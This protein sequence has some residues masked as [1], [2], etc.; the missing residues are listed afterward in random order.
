MLKRSYMLLIVIM[1][2]TSILLVSSPALASSLKGE[3]GPGGNNPESSPTVSIENSYIKA[4]SSNGGRFVN[5]TTGGD[6]NTP[7]DDNKRLLYGYSTDVGSS[8]STLR[9]DNG[10]NISDYR[11]GSVNW[12]SSGIAPVAPPTSDGITITTIWEKDGV[13]VEERIY[14]VQNSATGRTDTTAIEYTLRNNNSS[15]RSVGLRIMLDVMIGNNDGAPYFILGTGQVTQQAEWNGGNVPDYWTAYESPSF[16]PSSLKGRGQLVGDNTIRPDRFII[17]DWPQADETVWNYTI[18]PSDPV[19]NDSAVILYYNPVTLG[20]NQMRTIRTNYGIAPSG[21]TAQLELTGLE[22]TQAIQNW[23]NEVVLIQDR[24][25]YVR[26]HVQSTSG[27]VDDV[28]AELIGK[29]NGNSLPGS[30]LQPANIGG[31]IDI[32]ENPNRL[33]LN[34]SFFFELPASWRNGTIELELRGVNKTINC[35]DHTGT[36]ND[37]KAQVTFTASPAADVRF[38]GIVWKEGDIRHEPTW[39]DIH[40]VVKEIESTYPIPNLTWDRPYD[41]EPVFFVGQ[42][43]EPW[44]FNRMNIMLKINRTLDGCISGWPVYCNRYYLG[45]LVDPP[46]SGIVG[47]ADNIPANVATAYDTGSFTP[48]HELGHAAG[49]YHTTCLGEEGGPDPNYPYPGGRIS[50]DTS[51]DDAFFGFDI[52]RKLIYSPQTGDLMSYCKPR[53]TS[54]WTY[55]HIRDHFVTRYGSTANSLYLLAG[56]PAVVVSGIVTPNQESGNLSSL[57][58]VDS[59]ISVGLPDPGSYT[60]R[61]EN[62][63][64]QEIASYSFEPDYGVDLHLE[65]NNSENPIGTFALLLPRNLNATRVFLLHGDQI[66]DMQVKSSNSPNV[67][68]TYPNGGEILSDSSTQIGWIASDVDGDAL[69]YV[70]QYSNDGGDNWETL[71]SEWTTTS[72][73]LNLDVTPGTNQGLIRVLASDGFLTSQDQSDGI[74][75]IAKHAPQ[76]T[77]QIPE[78]NALFVGSQYIILEGNAYDAE[79]GLLEDS[80]LNWNSNINGNLG[81][82]HSLAVNASSLAEGTHIITLSAIDSDGQTSTTNITIQ[83]YR[84]RPVLP[85]L[86]SVSPTGLSFIA[87][88]DGGQTDWQTLSIRNVGDGSMSWSV[89]TDQEWIRVSSL[90]GYAPTDILIAVDPTGLPIGQYTGNLTIEASGATNSPQTL[91]VI[92][93]VR[94]IQKV[95]LPIIMK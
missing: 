55:T 51:G 32:L 39:G 70:V 61:F 26:A 67:A 42:P 50:Q 4:L 91:P 8:F 29:R 87:I 38:V 36:Y 18:N 76:P 12:G 74:F 73:E 14:F 15:N 9:I 1:G 37:C 68:V 75:T 27:T 54:D 69:T 45:I 43:S 62:S 20:A 5:G 40:S 31:N 71:V 23:K 94:Q 60:I 17:A 7:N 84:F 3:K 6:P 65:L 28:T 22:V 33:Q 81:T 59:P 21:E 64:G 86:L 2:L 78:T 83:I 49:R 77:I 80:A 90:N 95:Y 47:M 16:D 93:Y 13:R 63:I 89:N 30:P 92:L 56:E 19:T 24:P 46:T 58:S 10:G 41:I 25:T 79:D 88:E 72:Y 11:L 44:Q 85:A 35:K 52:D 48:A 82:G 34:D 57:L 66:L 53:W